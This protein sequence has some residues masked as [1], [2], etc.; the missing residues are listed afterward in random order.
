MV[1]VALGNVSVER[2]SQGTAAKLFG[3]KRATPSTAINDISTNFG[4]KPP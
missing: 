4:M 3:A 1:I 2:V